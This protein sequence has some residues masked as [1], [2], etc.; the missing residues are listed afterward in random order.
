MIRTQPLS[1]IRRQQ[2]QLAQIVWS[3]CFTHDRSLLILDP[4]SMA[5]SRQTLKGFR[6]WRTLSGFHRYYKS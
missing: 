3:K 6:G 1:Q 5:F 2:Q 4:L